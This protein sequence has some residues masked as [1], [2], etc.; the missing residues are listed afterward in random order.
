MIAAKRSNRTERS[1]MSP[2]RALLL[3]D[4]VDSTKLSLRLGDAEMANLWVAH[5]RAAR[6]LLPV[7]HGREIDKTDGMLLLF[8]AASDA[9]GYALAYQHA[10]NRLAWPL[11]ARAGLH[12]GPVT[13]RENSPSDVALGAKPIEVEGVAKATAARV[14]SVAMGG[15]ILLSADARQS[16]STEGLRLQSHGHWRLK[17]L[18]EPLELFEVGGD[19]APFSPPPDSDKAYRVVRQGE[20]WLP[21]RDIRHSLPAEGDVFVGRGDAL[22]ELSRRIQAGARLVSVFGIGGSGKTRLVTRYGHSWLGEFPG[23][24]WFCDLA[25]ARSLDGIA[26]AVAQGLEIP[27]GRGDPVVQIGNAI[28]GRGTCL[29]ILDNFEQVARHA[30]RTLGHWLA[31]ADLARFVVTTR[32]LLGLVGETVLGLPPMPLA[33]GAA[34]FAQRAQAA[35]PDFRPNAEDEASIAPLVRLLDGLPLAIELAAARVR[36]MA[37]RMLLARMSERF[38]L[39]ASKGGRLDR[40]STLRAAF[41]WSWDLLTRPERAAL[42][43]LSVFEGGFTLEAAEGVLDLSGF[44]DAPWPVDVVQSLV[45]KSFVRTRGGD[46]FDL[47]VSVQVYA[48]EHLEAEGHDAGSGPQ[49]LAAAQMRH[50]AWF[51]ALG[52]GRAAEGR[53]ADLDNL[54]AACR[55]AVSLG[56][57]DLA[58]GALEGAW[59]AL[60]LRGPFEA[61]VELAESVCAMPGLNDRAAAH[62]QSA[63][64]VALVACGRSGPARALYDRALAGAAAAGDRSCVALLTFRLGS[65][66]ESTGHMHEARAQHLSAIRMARELGDPQLECMANSGLGNVAVVEGHIDEA[67]SHYERALA[68]A[69]QTRDRYMQ[70][71]LLGNLGKL[72]LEIGRTDTALIRCEQSLAMARDTGNRRLESRQLCNLGM[73]YIVSD[74]PAQSE[75]ASKAALVVGRELGDLR[76]EA[77]VRC[78]LGI[79]IERQGRPDEARAE[80]ET[81]VGLAQALGD[82]IAEGQ[83]LSYLGLL[84]AR[85]GRHDEARTR[86]DC[87]ETLLRSASDAFGL[88]VLLTSR[89]EAHHLAG[90]A[91]KAAA[92]LTA[93]TTIAVDVG[94]GPASE[95]G[96]AL[97]RVQALIEPGRS[98]TDGTP[99]PNHRTIQTS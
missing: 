40:Q 65:L 86:L 74:R 93:A 27:L 78:N 90:D 19:D 38:K 4:V 81:A 25:S 8:E 71:N 95:I 77:I 75:T 72:H 21:V 9:V 83:F 12:V 10:L 24:V 22:A 91:A 26:S 49:A 48:A 46:R 11:Q 15:Q 16:L 58:T 31:R 47:L 50:L 52:P 61:G 20:L 66:H 67:L 29:V 69:G 14:M 42:A 82:P 88:G 96:L 7:W 2:P 60:S 5:D 33:E 23:G 53:C 98:P 51:A 89:A 32:E 99:G 41:D 73:L 56:V 57:G 68:L 3:T 45:D 55:R 34:L 28:A 13:L 87:G 64:A 1:S 43:Q 17:G 54:V 35:K 59:A 92:S 70:G 18:D 44:G 6:D 30:S 94:A 79:V 97:A 63:L 85:Q 84:Y 76:L 36:V 37:P 62:A 80:F 39:L